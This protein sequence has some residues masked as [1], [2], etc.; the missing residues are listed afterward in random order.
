[1]SNEEKITEI[2]NKI[3]ALNE[4]T[5]H[6][7]TELVSQKNS[8]MKKYRKDETDIKIKNLREELGI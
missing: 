1:M 6:Q 5:S 7:L 2:L 3:K 8:I 4:G